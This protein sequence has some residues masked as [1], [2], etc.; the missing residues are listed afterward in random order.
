MEVNR[1]E[2]ELRLTGTGP[3]LERCQLVG[4]TIRQDGVR[5]MLT[6]AAAL[7]AGAGL[8]AASSKLCVV[9]TFGRLCVRV[10]WCVSAVRVPPPR[11]CT[12]C[13]L[14]LWTLCGLPS[15]TRAL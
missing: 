8:R 12:S 7:M 14:C 15:P 4:K 6:V 11:A 10:W 2:F 5:R 3:L 9:C 13:G 1:A